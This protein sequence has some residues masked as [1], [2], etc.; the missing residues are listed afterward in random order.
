MLPTFDNR[1]SP[2]ADSAAILVA[3]LTIHS[4]ETVK[5]IAYFNHLAK[6]KGGVGQSKPTTVS[7]P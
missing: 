3:S 7:H 2:S 5:R 4:S 6:G 1:S